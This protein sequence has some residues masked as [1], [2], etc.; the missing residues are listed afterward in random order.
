MHLHENTPVL[1]KTVPIDEVPELVRGF[2]AWKGPAKGWIES[3]LS[4]FSEKSPIHCH[5][6][7]FGRGGTTAA[8]DDG[9]IE[10]EKGCACMYRTE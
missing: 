8:P 9:G 10:G 4:R 1:S 6:H 5:W 7:T 2:Y 3:V